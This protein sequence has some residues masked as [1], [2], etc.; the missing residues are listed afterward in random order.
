M[1]VSGK[2]LGISGIGVMRKNRVHA[3]KNNS[4]KASSVSKALHYKTK[5]KLMDASD[6]SRGVVLNSIAV[7][8]NSRCRLRF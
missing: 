4:H 5:A 8:I 1:A 6:T 7:N 2:N 3:E